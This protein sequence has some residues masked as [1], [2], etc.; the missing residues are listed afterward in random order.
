MDVGTPP[1]T[2]ITAILAGMVSSLTFPSWGIQ[3]GIALNT[4]YNGAPFMAF[5]HLA[6]TRPGLVV[7]SRINPG[8][9]IAWSGGCTDARQY[10]GSSNPTGHNFLN[11]PE[12]SS[13]PQTGI[14]LMRGPE[15]GVG[16]GW[17]T[18]PDPRL[19]PTSLLGIARI[20]ETRNVYMERQMLDVWNMFSKALGE[21]PQNYDTG[22]AAS[23]REHYATVNAGS[24]F[25]PEQPSIDWAGRSI[26]IQYFTGGLRCEWDNA[27]GGAAWYDYFNRRV[28]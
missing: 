23:W 5:L 4:P 7:G 26:N 1:N 19:N 28:I 13:Q 16:A 24:P 10:D 22:I 9:L 20:A 11:S 14:A 2:P 21:K 17:T 3:L 18:K 6:A 25:G 12:Q 8:D 27:N 15:Y